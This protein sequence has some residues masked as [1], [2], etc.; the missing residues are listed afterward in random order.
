[1]PR[2]PTGNPRGRPKGTGR[3]G[4]QTENADIFWP[5]VSQALVD[6]VASYANKRDLTLAEFLALYIDGDVG[7]GYR[8][9]P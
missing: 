2:K 4:A 3:R 7:V 5:G 8:R 6:E 9:L 1:M